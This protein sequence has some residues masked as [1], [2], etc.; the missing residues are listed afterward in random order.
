MKKTIFSIFLVVA[1]LFSF[2][3]P[4]F[5][6]SSPYDELIRKG[7]SSDCL[8]SLSNEMMTRLYNAIG[9]ND[10]KNVSTKTVY[11]TVNE[12]EIGMQPYYGDI[13]TNS[14]SLT[15][16]SAEICQ[17]GTN[18]ITGVLVLVEWIWHDGK[19]TI[20]KTDSIAVNWNSSIFY[21]ASDGFY[22]QDKWRLLGIDS[23]AISK[24]YTRPAESIQGGIGYYTK[25]TS[26]PNFRT[27]VGGNTLIILEPT[28]PMYYVSDPPYGTSI[29]VNYVH[30]RS[31][32]IP[33]LSFSNT[34]TAIGID[35]IFLSDS[36]SATKS[37]KYTR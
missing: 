21:L 1:L 16:D 15:I 24:E 35:T 30:N 14:L 36:A 29:S 27:E 7:F 4:A 32:V 23:W 34:G 37:F 5:A 28:S 6:S 20:R 10:I 9:N 8:D 17:K 26:D 11:L 31:L 3:A 33:T 2:T 12:T 13:S 19:P 25:L 18:R 22:S